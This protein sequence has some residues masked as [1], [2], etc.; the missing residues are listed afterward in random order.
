MHSHTPFQRICN[1]TSDAHIFKFVLAK[2]GLVYTQEIR[3]VGAAMKGWIL[4]Q[5]LY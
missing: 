4:A 3:Y 2:I 1:I 5:S